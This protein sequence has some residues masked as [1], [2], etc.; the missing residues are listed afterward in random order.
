MKRRGFI[1]LLGAATAWPIIARAQR[2]PRIPVIGF[3]GVGSPG[4]FAERIAA[5]RDGLRRASFV[6][7]RNL[8]IE[9]RWTE[10]GYDQLPDLAA[11]L[12][13][14]RVDVLVTG[15]GVVAAKSATASIHRYVQSSKM[16]HAAAAPKIFSYPQAG[17]ADLPHLLREKR[18]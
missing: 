4:P 18:K 6:E 15:N 3:F 11:E 9:F 10:G 13:D 17:P 7:G 12:V 14:R 1:T 16:V 5:F 8:A 2:P